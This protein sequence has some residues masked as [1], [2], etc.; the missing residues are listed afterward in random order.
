MFRKIADAL[1]KAKTANTPT[2]SQADQALLKK[3]AQLPD[4]EKHSAHKF[5]DYLSDKPK[6]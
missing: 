5:V 2:Q 3:I 6:R 1:I 4:D